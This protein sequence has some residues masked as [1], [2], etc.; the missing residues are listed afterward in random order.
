MLT[1]LVQLLLG[2]IVVLCLSMP[3]HSAAPISLAANGKALLPVIVSATASEAVKKSAQTLADYLARMSGTPFIVKTGDGTGGIAVGVFTDFPAVKTGVTFEAKDPLKRETY[4]LRSHARGVYL[5]GVGEIAVQDAVWDLLSRLGYRQFFPGPTWEV[6]PKVPVLRLAVDA[7]V[8]PSY[9]ARNIWYDYGTYPENM[10]NYWDW[11]AKNRA[12]GCIELNTGHAYGRI[13]NDHKT[14]FLAHP[15]YLALVNGKRD[16]ITNGDAKFCIANPDLRTLVVNDCLQHFAEDPKLDSLSLDPSDG[17][18]WCECD[19]CKALG[20]VTDRVV[21]LANEAAQAVNKQYPGKI[22][23]IYAYNMHSP[24]PTNVQVD[25]HV[26]ASIATAFISG[27]FTV[28]QLL[29]GWQAKGATDGIREYYCINP[30]DRNLPGAAY[31]SN[32]DYLQQTIP[33]YYSKGARFMS[34]ES[35]DC[36]GAA[37]LGYYFASRLLWNVGDAK[38]HK[39]ITA[40]FFEKAFGAAK[41]PMMAYYSHLDGSKPQLISEDLVG[42][43]YRDLKAARALT[44]D[45]QIL[46]RID[47]LILYT[48]YVELFKDY[49]N[50]AGETRLQALEQV[51]RFVYRI[52][53]TGMVHSLAIYRDVPAR[54]RTVTLP[55]NC[56]WETPEAKN[57]WKQG[58]PVTRQEIDGLLN[59]GIARNKLINFTPVTYSTNLV[60]AAKLKLP[61]VQDGMATLATRFEMTIYTWV[62]A[63]QGLVNLQYT[64][65]GRT[66][67]LASPK[68]TKG[69]II[70]EID[71]HRAEIV[72][73]DQPVQVKLKTPYAGLHALT[74][75][76]SSTGYVFVRTLG[77]LPMTASSDNAFFARWYLYFYVP[78]G[79]KVIGGYAETQDGN[80][81]DPDG[82]EA[83]SF[84]K[85]AKPDYFSVPVPPGQDG[86]LWKMNFCAG[87]RFLMTVPPYYA[88]NADELMLP[89][90]VVEKDAK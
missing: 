11:C 20:S 16:V 74:V 61:K 29:A 39:A 75:G 49:S 3:V 72:P 26:V 66:F 10:V 58:L 68:N 87:K 27:G 44:N 5:I 42:R 12:L 32:L 41:E 48:R 37:G 89:A 22:I 25:P 52:R 56:D 81:L 57:P 88:R 80:L 47:D 55:E 35:G 83:F 90:E 85:M 1:R 46:A 65:N 64:G 13:I 86:K 77:D 4:L 9:Y 31:A 60:P 28:D 84:V 24:P 79:T 15:E 2:A 54:D 53:K 82:K 36:W 70:G 34:A 38:N 21:T 78:K 8:S 67:S 6:V 23:G 73:A 33:H 51:C 62:P 30:W 14:E 17:N 7:V 45:P 50:A 59:D 71:L 69:G 76:G 43:M 40:D 19:Q 63:G 18:G